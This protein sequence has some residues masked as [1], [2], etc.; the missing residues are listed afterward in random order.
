MSE[1]NLREVE[2]AISELLKEESSVAGYNLLASLYIVQSHLMRA[3]MESGYSE[4]SAPES[5]TRTIA[6][7]W[8][9]S[10]KNSDG[11]TGLHWS[12]DQAKQL[13]QQRKIDCDPVEF[14]AAL[15]AV[16][17]D[18]CAVAKKHGVNNVEFF[19]DLAKAW[20]DDEDAVSDKASAYYEYV[21]K[22]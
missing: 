21:V 18:F 8:V 2:W 22:H 6:D 5:F 3:E 7:K 16:F 13:M 20:I 4:K 19:I 11:S 9:S 14:Y 10:M 1:P 12:F 15:N 17:S